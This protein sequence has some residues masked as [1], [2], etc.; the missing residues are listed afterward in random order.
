MAFTAADVKNLREMTGVGMMDCKKALAESDGNMD[1]AINNPELSPIYPM[2]FAQVSYKMPNLTIYA[3]CE[4]IAN[5]KQ[6]K[7]IQG[8]ENPYAPGFNSSM[9]WGPLSGIKGYIGIR[10][11]IY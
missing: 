7:P 2:F 6:M 4:N 8:F 3:G 9:V 10:L 5:F 1:K 11:N